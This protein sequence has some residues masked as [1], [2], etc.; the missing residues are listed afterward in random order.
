MGIYL[1]PGN[2]KFQEAL[3]SEIYVDKTGM[4]AY[5]NAVFQTNQ[6]YICISRPRR[7]GKSM[8]A[9]MLAAYYDITVDS[10]RQFDNLKIAT[11]ESYEKRINQYNV[12]AINMQ[13]FLSNATNID[14]ML[15]LLK[16]R[17]I[18]E[19]KAQNE[20]CVL[21]DETN[22]TFTL[23]D[24]YVRKKTPY[25]ILIDEW[26][27]IFRERQ[28]D[29]EGQ[30]KYLDFLRD[31]LKDREYIA[32]AYMTGILPIKKYGS[33]SALNMFQEFSMTNQREL[34]EFVGFTEEE[35]EEICHRYNRDFEEMKAW[36]DGYSFLKVKSVYNPKAV[37]E[38]ALSGVFD[39]YWT[40]TETYEAL[41]KYIEMDYDGLREAVTKMLAGSYVRINTGRFSND[42]TTFENADDVMSLL[43][44][45]GYLAYD[46]EQEAVYIPN[47]EISKEF[48]NAVEGAGWQEIIATIKKSRELLESIWRLEEKN[49]AEGIE[50][51]HYETSVLQYNDENALSY[52][53]SLALYAAREY[54]TVIREMPTGKGFADIVYIPRKRYADKPAIIVELKRNKSIHG[55]IAQ[56]KDKQYVKGLEE[57]KGKLLLVG[58][59]YD[60]IT[61]KHSCVIEEVEKEQI[62][63]V[64]KEME[65]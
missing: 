29:T 58:I 5:T 18:F 59:S 26:D 36:Y 3:N 40:K 48:Y 10:H 46:F 28:K 8:A 16:R 41:K 20:D 35:V 30:K 22:L 7:F 15:S 31:L 63:M 37:V 21:F 33:H 65:N 12:I 51:A 13:E 11:D 50:Q 43:I 24:I 17:V 32:L 64:S 62:D 9:N 4:L 49:V 55:A 47:R 6:K 23:Q 38:A 54:Y 19:L 61:K 56:I 25:V 2:G 34:E 27:C 42:M 57:Y 60:S 44:H 45:L 39:S 53:V 14:E 1:N 52:T